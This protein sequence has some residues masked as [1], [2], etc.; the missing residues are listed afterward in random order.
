MPRKPNWAQ[1]E[2]KDGIMEVKLLSWKYFHDYI[3][4]EML[5]FSHYFW[6]GQ[7]ESK[8]KLE[9]SLGRL[10]RAK[11]ESKRRSYASDLPP[12]PWTAGYATAVL[13]SHP[14]GES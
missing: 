14:V 1:S 13:A 6:R 10:L 12:I 4:K 2:I 3:R 7:R 5:D 9:S 8:W 11:P